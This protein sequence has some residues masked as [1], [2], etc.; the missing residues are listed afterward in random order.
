[1]NRTYEI[2]IILISSL[3]LNACQE[4]SIIE[5]EIGSL[6]INQ[7]DFVKIDTTFYENQSIEK[8]RFIKSDKEDI[9]LS[10]YRNG[11]KKSIIPVKDSQVHGECI[12]WYENGQIKW[13]RFYDSGNS[14]KQSTNYD[15]NG[16]RTKIDDFT[17]G[18]FTEFYDNDIPRLKRSDKLYIDYYLN[19]QIKSSIIG[20]EDGSAKVKYYNEYGKLSFNGNS[21]SDFI[22][23]KNDS[24]FT[25][26]ITSKFTDGEIAFQQSFID[27][28]PNGKCI[29][30]FGNKN[31]EYELE[32]LNG[33]EI[34][35]HK[36]Y[37]LNGSIQSIKNFETK[38]YKQWDK[39]GNLVE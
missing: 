8:L 13:K 5:S 35:I 23:F 36:R 14:I 37:H 21:N 17:D 30:R 33:I 26:T 24:L 39:K 29:S 2:L 1:M 31:L 34:G 27:G 15:E 25:G 32:F 4:K 20:K 19:G 38:E 28:L 11:K 9:R 3:F 10:F 6:E 7:G 18:S 22:L 16:N 12:D